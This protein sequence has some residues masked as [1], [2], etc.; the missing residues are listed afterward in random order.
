MPE[1]K[2]RGPSV[3]IVAPPGRLRDALQVMVRAVPQIG[4]TVQANDALAVLRAAEHSPALV[5]LDA[6]LPGDEAWTVLP[7]IKARWPQTRC[8]VLANNGQQRQMA[9]AHG[10]DA[11]LSRGFTVTTLTAAVASLYP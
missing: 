9:N 11:V 7:Q 1:T 4:H 6:D 8:I 3:L 5:L 2:P 10:A